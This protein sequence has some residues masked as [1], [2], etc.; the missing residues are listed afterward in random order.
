MNLIRYG[1]GA[2]ASSWPEPMNKAKEK[3]MISSFIPGRRWI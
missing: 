1:N 3:S 2:N